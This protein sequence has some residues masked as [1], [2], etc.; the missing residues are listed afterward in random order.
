M[1]ESH[2]YVLPVSAYVA[3]VLN[4]NN[5]VKLLLRII[6]RK[7]RKNNQKRQRIF[8]RSGKKRW[9]GLTYVENNLYK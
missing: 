9:K 3:L 8:H 5:F 4:C 6:K 2:R 7:K 1:Q